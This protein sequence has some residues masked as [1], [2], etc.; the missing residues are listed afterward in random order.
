MGDGWI[1]LKSRRYVSFKKGQSNEPDPSRWT[2]PLIQK[3]VR[4]LSSFP[5]NRSQKM[6]EP[7]ILCLEDGGGLYTALVY[8]SSYKSAPAMQPYKPSSQE[9]VD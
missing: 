3:Y 2:V 7:Y 8:V 4:K 5:T 9:W 1:F 6:G